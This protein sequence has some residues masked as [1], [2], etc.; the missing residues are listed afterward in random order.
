LMLLVAAF[1]FY[2]TVT[3]FIEMI[4]TIKVHMWYVG[5]ATIEWIAQSSKIGIQLAEKFLNTVTFILVLV[6]SF[7]IL[8]SYSR[9]HHISVKDLLEISII[10]LLMEVVFNFWLHSMAINWLFAVLAV[11]LVVIYAHYP[12]FHEDWTKK[13]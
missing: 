11:F 7:K 9:N 3:L 12:M 1:I 5:H 8:I 13:H 2:M 6:K 4:S 10:G